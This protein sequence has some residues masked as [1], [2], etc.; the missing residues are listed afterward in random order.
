[1]TRKPIIERLLAK[2]EIDDSGC[3]I[4]RGAHNRAGY[5]YI[6]NPHDKTGVHR[7]SYEFYKGP[8]PMGLQIDHLCRKPACANPDHLEAVSCRVNILRGVSPAAR[9]ARQTHCKRGHPLN[10]LNTYVQPSNGQ[11]SCKTCRQ[12]RKH[13]YWRATHPIIRRHDKPR[14]GSIPVLFQAGYAAAHNV[15]DPR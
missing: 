15:G 9:E 3:W 4:W 10:L 7:A 5:G 6:G 12:E 11:R 8:I 14:K 1:M 2:V 13:R